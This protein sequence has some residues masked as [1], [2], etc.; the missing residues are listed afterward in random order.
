MTI[1]EIKN[2]YREARRTRG[3]TPVGPFWVWTELVK[4]R[5]GYKTQ[6]YAR[7]DGAKPMTSDYH[8]GGWTHIDTAADILLG[9]W[10]KIN[11]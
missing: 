5:F 3:L 11:G 6:Y 7:I 8:F 2:A 9:K 1:T 10:R 4:H